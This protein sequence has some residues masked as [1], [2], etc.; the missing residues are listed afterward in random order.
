MFDIIAIAAVTVL[1]GA[2]GL[3]CYRMGREDAYD[4]IEASRFADKMYGRA[5]SRPASRDRDA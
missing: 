1:I 2:F 4:T 5:E 3:A